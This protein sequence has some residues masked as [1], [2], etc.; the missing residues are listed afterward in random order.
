MLRKRGDVWWIDIQH[1]GRR[2]RRSSGTTD[3]AKAQEFHDRFKARLWEQAKLGQAPDV[4]LKAA[5]ASWWQAVGRHKRS[6]SDD[7]L[8]LRVL[9]PLIAG[10]TVQTIGA[11]HLREIRFS[12]LERGV[13]DATANRYM[14]LLSAILRHAHKQGWTNR[15]P[16]IP[17]APEDKGRIRWITRDEAG[18]LLSELPEHLRRM[19]SFTLATGLRR[20]NVTHLR[21]RLV[22]LPRATAY[23]PPEH[24]KS[25]K[26]IGVPLNGDALSVLEECRGDDPEWVFVYKGEPVTR[27][28]TAAWRKACAR[29]GLPDL[30]WH[31]LRHTWASWHVMSGTP[32]QVL[33]E[34]GG[35][36]SLDMVL[37]Y[38]HLAPDHLSEAA[39]NIEGWSQKRHSTNPVLPE[40]G[41]NI[42]TNMGWLT[43]LEPATTGITIRD[44]TD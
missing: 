6:G 31:D 37:R 11:D 21:W 32:V 35:W 9:A 28:G 13:T 7:V 16:A 17:H 5:A 12:V 18:R 26:A 30:H 29:A 34:L 36:A 41:G 1:S 2:I 44:S 20:H 8:K 14:A 39:R 19:A 43:G 27:T 25:G 22:D 40:N 24:A 33:K 3:R 23:I 15:V 38:A 10:K 4:T 42:L